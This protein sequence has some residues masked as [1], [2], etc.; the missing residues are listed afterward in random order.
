MELMMSNKFR[1]YAVAIAAMVAASPV[2]A[3]DLTS[4]Y[5]APPA[6]N[7]PAS[8]SWT[9]AYAGGHIGAAMPSANPF[10]DGKGLALGVQGGY[11]YDLGG[12]VVGGELEATH[13]GDTRVSVPNGNLRERWRVAAKAKAGV[14]MDQTLIYGTAGLTVTSLRDGD[15]VVGPDGMK[16]GYLLGAGIEHKFNQQ[17]SGKVEYNYVATN[18]VRTFSG[19]T[20]SRT[21]ISDNVVKGGLNY[22]F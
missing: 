14:K 9:G 3:A 11:N 2:V 12:A 10:R 18:D 1:S 19:G 5:E 6:Y 7:E 17:I 8:S 20:T 13:L 22:H 16:E 21:D 15:N 4:S